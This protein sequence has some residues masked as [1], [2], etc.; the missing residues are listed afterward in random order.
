MTN[1]LSSTW[2]RK[3][4]KSLRLAELAMNSSKCLCYYSRLYIFEGDTYHMT[5]FTL[6]DKGIYLKNPNMQDSIKSR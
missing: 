1:M 4:I 2:L 5:K 3:M 6:G